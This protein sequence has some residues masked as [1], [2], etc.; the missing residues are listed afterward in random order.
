MSDLFNEK[1]KGWDSNDL[2]SRLS[3]AIGASIVSHVPLHA[4]MDV[5]DFGAGTGLIS[6]HVA[7]FVH[8]IVAVDISEA[9]LN[10]L[11]RKKELHG[12]VDIL[13]RNILDEPIDARFDLIMSAMAM[14]HVQ[15]TDRLIQSFSEHLKPGAKV[16]LADLDREDGNFH[17]KDTQGVFHFG[18]E[19]DKL[20]V[21][22]EKHGF[23][24]VDF[25]TAY[26]LEKEGNSFPIFL[27]TATKS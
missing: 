14:H 23:K 24:D 16:A 1:A 22:L 3:A 8:K 13:C 18:F 21:L 7:P 4:R 26:T 27:V 20:Q 15:D 19:R 6:S 10:E 2:T 9:M 5:M 11:L 12:K 17:P 25:V